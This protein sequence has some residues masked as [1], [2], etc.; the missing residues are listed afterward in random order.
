MPFVLMAAAFVLIVAAYQN[1]QGNLVTAL[2]NDVPGFAPFA[3]AIV[4]TGAVGFIPKLQP[5]SR[6]LLGLLFLVYVIRNWPG[7]SGGITGLQQ[8]SGVTGQAVPDPATQY[9]TSGT[10]GRVSVASI[11][12]DAATGQAAVGPAGG[13][14][15]GLGG[16]GPA[17]ASAGFDPTHFLAAFESGLG[18]FGGIA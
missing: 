3:L 18:G 5:V 4:G 11:A 17:I 1:T 8:L 2:E 7:I 9:A 16:A 13:L 14:P 15:G 10:T 6:M 12:G